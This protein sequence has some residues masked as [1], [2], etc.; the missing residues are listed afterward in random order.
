MRGAYL[1][2][3][4]FRDVVA[5][6]IGR[7]LEGAYIEQFSSHCATIHA[8]HPSKRRID[9]LLT[10]KLRLTDRTLVPY[11]WARITGLGPMPTDS[12]TPGF[13]RSIIATMVSITTA[14]A[15]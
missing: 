6:I 5:R 13:E 1:A 9:F 14:K 4:G 3:S 15:V 7:N 8:D 10:Y 2:T 11:S 12:A